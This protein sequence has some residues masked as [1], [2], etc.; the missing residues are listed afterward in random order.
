MPAP[1]AAATRRALSRRPSENAATVAAGEAATASTAERGEEGEGRERARLLDQG[2]AQHPVLDDP[3]ERRVGSELAVIVMQ[4]QRR[5][6]VGDADLAD[7]LGL[8]GDQRP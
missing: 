7:R 2:A 1:S 5:V 3:A 6:V 4:E 8:G